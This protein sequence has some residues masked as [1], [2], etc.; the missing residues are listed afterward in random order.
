MKKNLTLLLLTFIVQN[1]LAQCQFISERDFEAAKY[2]LSSNRGNINTFQAAMDVSRIYCLSS[3]Q[4]REI[5]NYLANDRDKFDFLKS[6]FQDI[7]D[8]ENFTDVMDVFRLFSSALKLYHQTLGISP[9]SPTSLP[10]S[11]NPNCLRSMSSSTYNA[12]RT[13]INAQSDD[14]QKASTIL[15]PA[16]QCM[17]VQ[18]IIALSST[19][20][21]ENIQLDILKRLYPRVFDVENYPQAANILSSNNRNQFLTFLQN[22][23]QSLNPNPPSVEMTE[24]DFNSFIQSIKKQS[25]DKDKES[26]VK[27][28]MKN[29]YLSTHQISQ[30][31]KQL[32]FDATKLDL[33]KFLFDRCVDKQN[34]FE[35][36]NELQF[37]SSKTDL[38]DF[39]KTRK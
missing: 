29:A 33:A 2:R 7:T 26:Y 4:A 8:K 13:Q 31:L 25:F 18:Q 36:A 38:N 32:S 35:V 20:R 39:I 34:Y 14:R 15:N 3:A 9:N 23:S 12:L 16:N 22:P 17:T 1:F 37:S 24:L 11:S 5:A 21:D 6:C 30:I 27:T 19:V 10:A 28:Y